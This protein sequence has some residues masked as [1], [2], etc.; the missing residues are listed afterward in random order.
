MKSDVVGLCMLLQ[1]FKYSKNMVDSWGCYKGSVEFIWDF[2][3]HGFC[4]ALA[5]GSVKT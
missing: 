2:L 5:A 1:Y 4:T 3:I